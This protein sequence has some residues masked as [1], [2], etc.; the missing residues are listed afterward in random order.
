M[1]R[2]SF[3]VILLFFAPAEGDWIDGFKPKLL[4]GL[5]TQ[6]LNDSN[7]WIKSLETIATVSSKCLTMKMCSSEEIKT[8]EENLYAAQELDA[9]GHFPVP[10]MLEIATLYDG[11]YQECQ[12]VSGQKYDTNYCYVLFKPGENVSCTSSS[13][14]N[15]LSSLPFR[16][17][18]CIPKSCDHND[19]INFSNQLA[20]NLV[21][22]C[23]VYCVSNEIKKD[24]SFWGF[25]IFL[26]IMVAIAIFATLVDYIRD[27]VYG[28]KSAKEK[29]MFLKVLLTFSMWTNAEIL[30]SVKE[31]KPGFIK[32]LDCIR[33]LSMFWVV[34]GH[35]F[36]Y[37]F[38]SDTF[39]PVINFPKQFW[40]H[41][42]LN[43]V[44]SVDTFFVLS[45]IVLSYLFFK[46]KPSKRA[47]MSPITWIMFYVH[48]YLRLT[49][50]VMIFIGFFAV[51]GA[52]IQGPFAASEM[53]MIAAQTESCK[54][55]WWQNL[56]YINNFAESNTPCYAPTWY[57]AVDTQLYF[58]APIFLVALYLSF[59]LGTGLIIATC[60]G[61]IIATYIIFSVNDLPADMFRSGA[62]FDF[63]K[64]AYEKPWVR[65]PPYFMG[66][67]T[68]YL[69]GVYGNRKIRLNW[70]L[71]VAG[72]I[73]AFVIAGFCLFATYDYDKGADWSVFTRATFYNFHRI[74][75]ALFIC[76]VVSANHM[77]W[78]GP[79]DNFMSHP[80]WQPFG[81]LSYCAYIVHW[82]VL[83]YFLNLGGRPLH[84]YSA[85]ETFTYTALPAT[86]LSFIVAFFWSCLFE[87]PILKL[88]KMLIEWLMGSRRGS[89]KVEDVKE[90]KYDSSAL[91]K[92]IST[93][94]EEF[95][96]NENGSAQR[97]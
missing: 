78:G 46:T 55:S 22:A 82:L 67:F 81:R 62:N 25:S 13:S 84:Y 83:F 4:H 58:V 77:G 70:A 48:R 40:N 41:L 42:L 89:R 73:I 92:K 21:K 52:Y 20:P 75:W 18:V 5:S 44:V 86:V 87:V 35:S 43:A 60:V 14:S 72:W 37:L 19:I 53:N 74:G 54:T 66:I 47:I 33:M 76:W 16:L 94:D 51:Y 38:L 96:S 7:T 85:W 80:M 30:L 1:T 64:I 91:E 12:R 45:G 65:C 11:S 29:M 61:S 88:E 8:L 50:P 95:K 17:A 63:F 31:Q 26:M 71:S 10:G 93:W 68:G 27:T 39:M 2:L 15:P 59:A 56:L 23:H 69:L 57:L 90:E 79:I 6:C 49:P 28:I 24:S 97:F 32:S 36:V 34:T 3:A 9:F